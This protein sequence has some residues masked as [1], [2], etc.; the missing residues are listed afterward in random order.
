MYLIQL[1]LPL[2]DNK[3]RAFPNEYFRAVRE[4]LAERFGGVTAFLRSPAVGLWKDGDT[5]V[6]QDEVVMY[7]VISAELDTSWWE[8]YRKELQERFCQEELLIWATNVTRL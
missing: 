2:H 8:T 1:L 4:T 7:E 3:R 6:S 5:D